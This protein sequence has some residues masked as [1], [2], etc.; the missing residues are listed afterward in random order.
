MRSSGPLVLLIL[1]FPSMGA[2]Q[3]ILNVE[4]LQGEEV[5]G[6]HG[7]ISG[8]LR[9]ASG[10]TDLVQVGGDVGIGHLSRRH[11]IRTYLGL[12]RLEE[13]GKDVL[14][15]RYLHLRYNYCFSPRARTFHFFQLQANRNLLLDQRRLLGSGI[16]ARILGGAGNR[17][18]VGTGLM[19]ESERLNESRLAPGEDASTD[20]VRMANLLAGSGPVGEGNRWVTV[21]YYQPNVEGFRD[22]RL[23]G[24]VGLRAQILASLHVDLSVTWRHDSRAPAGLEPDDVEIKTGFTYSVG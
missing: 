6:F 19:L 9:L 2:G 4:V 18:E 20:A 7:E 1:L 21:V 15:N 5:E 22:Y 11:W 17:L 8:R 23:L 16:R 10:N 12:E 13:E 14:Y 3:A 24:E